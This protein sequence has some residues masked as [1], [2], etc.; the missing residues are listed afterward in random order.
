VDR[1]FNQFAASRYWTA[2]QT[3]GDGHAPSID[4]EGPRFSPVRG[5]HLSPTTPGPQLHR[6]G[7]SLLPAQGL[8]RLVI[9]DRPPPAPHSGPDSPAGFLEQRP[10]CGLCVATPSW[11]AAGFAAM[12]RSVSP[13]RRLFETLDVISEELHARKIRSVQN[14]DSERPPPFRL[15]KAFPFVSATKPPPSSV[16]WRRLRDP[17]PLRTSPALAGPPTPNRLRAQLIV[18]KSRA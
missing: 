2:T 7:L 1:G 5:P 15:K 13:Y 11:A 14:P 17:V 8:A 6:W 12:S 9:P 3:L 16:F 10:P 4:G 18:A